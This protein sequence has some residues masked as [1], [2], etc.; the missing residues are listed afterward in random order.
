MTETELKKVE[1]DA[2]AT[3]AHVDEVLHSDA[4]KTQAS[5]SGWAKAHTSW[6][7]GLVCLVIGLVLGH[8]HR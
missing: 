6:L 1:G 8:L 3:L 4:L 2:E 7:V 5:I